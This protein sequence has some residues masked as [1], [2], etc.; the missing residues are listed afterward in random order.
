MRNAP[1]T[2]IGC[3]MDSLAAVREK[4]EAARAD[5]LEA[6]VES[7]A[8]HAVNVAEF[9]RSLAK[10]LEGFDLVPA[11][12]AQNLLQAVAVYAVKGAK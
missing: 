2:L 11:E 1:L 9:A 4:S 8:A 10:S 12:A 5:C 6:M 7:S 3:G